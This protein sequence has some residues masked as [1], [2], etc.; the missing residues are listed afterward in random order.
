MKALTTFVLS[1]SVAAISA[2]SS[3]PPELRKPESKNRVPVNS[4]VPQELQQ[5]SPAVHNMKRGIKHG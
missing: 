5:S 4:V 1:V 2:C 3:A